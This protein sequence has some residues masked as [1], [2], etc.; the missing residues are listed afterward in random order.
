MQAWRMAAVCA[1]MGLATGC[2]SLPDARVNYYLPRAEVVL[3]VERYVTCKNDRLR[4]WP[5]ATLTAA[6]SA[7]PA[8]G[9]MQ[10][11]LAALDRW[12]AGSEL[13]I[14][15]TA[16]GRLA[17]INSTNQGDGPAWAKTAAS[18]AGMAI[19][20][21]TV[22]ALPVAKMGGPL[23]TEG[24]EA[25]A[26]RLLCGLAKDAPEGVAVFPYKARLQF[27]DPMDKGAVDDDFPVY[28]YPRE[29]WRLEPAFDDTWAERALARLAGEM[30]ASAHAQSTQAPTAALTVCTAKEGAR[31]PDY[32]VI[33]A[34]V[35]VQYEVRL[36]EKDR[37]RSVGVVAVPQAGRIY[38]LPLPA[39]RLFGKQTAGLVFA[40]DGSLTGIAYGSTGGAA[41]LAEGGT[42]LADSITDTPAERAERM[43][44][45]ADEIAGQARLERCLSDPAKCELR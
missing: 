8:R 45:Q 3:K 35:P 26:R 23:A 5:M 44:Q 6:Y 21:G 18:L 19:S 32:P 28:E 41:A 42:S 11:D 38:D 10:L 15:L 37:E 2:A 29:T 31:C 36:L 1:T 25:Q 43:N 12:Y 40:A 30:H 24:E 27:D 33:R 22:P 9:P 13:A 34:R 7:D 16:D 39:P 17:S 20:L 4:M 14:A